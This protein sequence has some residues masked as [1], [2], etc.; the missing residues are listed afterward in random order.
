VVDA[1]GPEEIGAEEIGAEDGTIGAVQK[2]ALPK[3]KGRN[4]K[5]HLVLSLN[6]QKKKRGKGRKETE[7]HEAKVLAY[8]AS[9]PMIA[10]GAYLATTSGL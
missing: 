4:Q 2:L 5:F 6:L 3:K 7:T 8:F 9:F 1:G 10:K